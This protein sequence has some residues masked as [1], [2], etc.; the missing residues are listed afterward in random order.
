MKTQKISILFIVVLIIGLWS[1]LPHT[2]SPTSINPF[3]S[4]TFRDDSVVADNSIW[5]HDCSNIS[6]FEYQEE[7]L[8]N[9]YGA[10]W[11]VAEGILSSTSGSLRFSGIDIGTGWHGPIYAIQ[12]TDTI[13]VADI[14]ELRLEIEADNSVNDYSARYY[15]Y[16]GDV[17]QRP[18]Y[19]FTIG[20]HESSSHL[21]VYG[22]QY[23]YENYTYFGWGS[24]YPYSFTGFDGE[25]RIS[26]NESTRVC[27]YVDGFGEG[28]LATLDADELVREIKYIVLMGGRANTASLMPAWIHNFSITTSTP[29]LTTKTPS[30]FTYNWHHDC[31]NIT[32]FASEN[33]WE[34]SWY[35]AS[36][37]VAE[38][39]L[40]SSSG[41]LSFSGIDAGSGWHG[42]VYSYEFAQPF[43]VSDVIEFAAEIEADNSAN[44]YLARYY[45]YLGDINQRPTYVFTIGDHQADSHLGVYGS[46]YWY[47]DYYYRGWGSPYPYSFTEFNGI[48][49]LSLDD[50]DRVHGYVDGFGEGSFI[51][52]DENELSREIHYLVLMGGR[53]NAAPLMP[54][55]IHD[56]T[57]STLLSDSLTIDHPADVVFE[58]GTSG[59]NITWTPSSILPDSYE[60]RLN[61][62]LDDSDEWNGSQIVVSLDNLIPGVYSY[63]L[64]VFDKLGESVSDAVAVVVTGGSENFDLVLVGIVAG[65]GAIIIVLII[66]IIKNR[67]AT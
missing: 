27:G 30:P 12:L 41:S 25:M 32:N 5:H 58:Y 21:G 64:T 23:W 16:L 20:D 13:T 24:P 45:L 8:T 34:T 28:D 63:N 38:G 44:E 49:S 33:I 59:K 11:T 42:P 46:Q 66:V 54:A 22:S 51:S 65:A 37:T 29:L 4:N 2:E 18:T 14:I 61:S 47:E 9:W 62:Q 43:R 60:L 52:L 7:W 19:V 1:T 3:Y 53:A 36:W 6:G 17:N 39:I 31:S 48:M 56:I 40:S 26:L 15:L 35:G 57:L 10:S 55:W 67:S 50:S